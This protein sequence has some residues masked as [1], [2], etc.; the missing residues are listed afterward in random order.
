[1]IEPMEIWMVGVGFLT[2]MA[3]IPQ[4]FK[5]VERKSSDDLSM[6]AW[7]VI[8][9]GQCSWLRYG[10]DNNSISLVFCNG[11]NILFTITIMILCT[12]YS[13][14]YKKRFNKA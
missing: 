7:F 3:E 5:L 13:E 1:M 14:E 6:F 11:L 8:Y 10:Y 2:A 9:F 4:I 12:I